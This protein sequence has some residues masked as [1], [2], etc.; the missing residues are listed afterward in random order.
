MHYAFVD[1]ESEGYLF[2]FEVFLERQVR[3]K[4]GDFGGL[5]PRRKFLMKQISRVPHILVVCTSVPEAGQPRRGTPMLALGSTHTS[6]PPGFVSS[7]KATLGHLEAG[8]TSF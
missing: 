1:S 8:A 7:L 4:V 2:I 3:E 5:P 6:C